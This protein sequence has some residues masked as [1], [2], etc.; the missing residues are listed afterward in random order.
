MNKK[1]R[2]WMQAQQPTLTLMEEVL[3]M[4]NAPAAKY[5]T[6]HFWYDG[7]HFKIE[8]GDEPK[9][10]GGMITKGELIQ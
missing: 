7:M 4:A 9:M 3:D 2:L 6:L 5:D 10:T 1:T 8:K